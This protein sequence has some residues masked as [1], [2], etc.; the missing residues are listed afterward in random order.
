MGTEILHIVASYDISDPK[1]LAK[2][3]RTMKGYG[4]R[5]LKSVFECNLD[6]GKF[7]EMKTKIDE[8]IEPIEDSVRYYILC[9]KCLREVEYSGKGEL[10][11]EDEEYLV[12]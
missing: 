11:Q 9:G 7:G 12:V 6:K 10:F 8:I 1:R 4:E 2:V 3:A 5:V